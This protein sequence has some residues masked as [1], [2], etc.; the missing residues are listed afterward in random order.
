MELKRDKSASSLYFQIESIIKEQIENGEYNYGDILP[1]ENELQRIYNVSRVT[2]RQAMK[3]LA[4]D[5]YLKSARGIGTMVVFEKIDENVKRVIS[6]SKE[7]EQ[8]GITME[9]SYCRMSIEKSGKYVASKLNILEDDEVYKLVRVRCVKNAPL[10]YS[11]TY[12]KKICEFSLDANLYKE[13]LYN[14]LETQYGIKIVKGQDTFEATLA[15]KR[16]GEFLKI[17]E[18]AP[19][20]K[21]SRITFDQNENIVE[22]TYCYY[23]GEK[24]KYSVDL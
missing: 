3:D 4:N 18:G 8:H 19:V 20:F 11:I 17:S 12:L 15:D 6:F 9:T 7:M 1:S 2:I 22:Y 24:Y 10:V 14:L 5:G 23:P 13:S 16:I 21:R